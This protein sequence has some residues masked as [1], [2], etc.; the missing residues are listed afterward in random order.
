MRRSALCGRP[1]QPDAGSVLRQRVALL[2]LAALVAGA[3]C[4]SGADPVPSPTPTASPTATAPPSATASPSATVPPSA[5][6]SPPATGT[7]SAAPTPTAPAT[8]IAPTPSGTAVPGLPK[9]LVGTVVTVI[10]TTA[11]VAAL[12]FD[13]GASDAGVPSILQALAAQRVTATFFVTGDFARRYPDAVRAMARAGHLVGNHSDTHPDFTTLTAAQLAAQLTNAESVIGPLIAGTTQPWFRFPFGA[14]DAAAIAGVNAGGYAG[15][16]WTVDTLG[17]KGTSGGQSVESV[18][19]RVIAALR[20]GAI[21]LMHVGAN[22]DDGSTL[23][24]AALPTII[25]E[26]RQRGYGFVTVAAALP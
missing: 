7:P 21:V 20:P 22:P 1:D 24:A 6:L 23:D 18:V 5:T 26:L 14:V 3:G 4:G 19:S 2:I 12:T 11:R 16:G 17:W 9:A 25:A 13:A 8:P 15:I 10:P